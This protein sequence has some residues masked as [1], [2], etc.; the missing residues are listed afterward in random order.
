MDSHPRP[1]FKNLAHRN[2][3][4]A[5]KESVCVFTS[6]PRTK[7]HGSGPGLSMRTGPERISHPHRGASAGNRQDSSAAGEMGVKH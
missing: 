1:T 3:N 2:D 5:V 4:S 6:T 7:P